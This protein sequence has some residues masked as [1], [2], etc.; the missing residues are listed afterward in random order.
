MVITG[1]VKIVNDE[2]LVALDEA[3]K[4]G[5]HLESTHHTPATSRHPSKG[6]EVKTFHDYTDVSSK[7][8]KHTAASKYNR[9]LHGGPDHPEGAFSRG[10]KKGHSHS[11]DIK[12]ECYICASLKIDNI[13]LPEQ[14]FTISGYIEVYWRDDD[15]TDTEEIVPQKAPLP[16]TDMFA[17]A[18]HEEFLSDPVHIFLKDPT[19][20]NKKKNVIYGVYQFQATCSEN[21]EMNEFPFDRQV[22]NIKTEIATDEFEVLRSKPDWIP[23]QNKTHTGNGP[24]QV[25]RTLMG[26]K[27][28]GV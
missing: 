2:E 13:D 11:E 9:D 18:T 1:D 23:K 15:I 21:F 19:R 28:L 10:R 3:F 4:N 14:N 6:G 17:N 20:G 27:L 25:L 5:E 16:W 22:L 26:E 12:R 7:S 24:N 8:K